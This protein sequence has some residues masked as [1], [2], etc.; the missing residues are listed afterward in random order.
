MDG[1]SG[2]KFVRNVCDYT[3]QRLRLYDMTINTY[4]QISLV[5]KLF[6]ET[7]DAELVRRDG[8]RGGRNAI[9]CLQARGRDSRCARRRDCVRSQVHGR[10]SLGRG[11]HR[12]EAAKRVREATEKSVRA[13][14]I[15]ANTWPK[16][17]RYGGVH[18]I[19]VTLQI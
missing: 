9:E 4:L 14:K 16:Y 7:A 13:I 11:D 19:D 18:E 1:I 5:G 10:F 17:A 15:M 6:N 12:R 8:G 3:D 2:L